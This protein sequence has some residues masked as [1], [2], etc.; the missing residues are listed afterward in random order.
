MVC[1]VKGSKE[2]SLGESSTLLK[3]INEKFKG[4]MREDGTNPLYDIIYSDRFKRFWGGNYEFKPEGDPQR[5][6]YLT[7]KTLYSNKEHLYTT[8]GEPDL[9][10]DG[11]KAYFINYK[12][13][14]KDLLDTEI[15][16][17]QDLLDLT[18]AFSYHYLINKGTDIKQQPNV[19]LEITNLLNKFIGINQELMDTLESEVN[20]ED[21]TDEDFE[22]P[23][24][25]L[26]TQNYDKA[27]LQNQ[28]LKNL[29]DSSYIFDAMISGVKNTLKGIEI[30]YDA[31]VNMDEDGESE[32][33]DIVG[34]STDI[35]SHTKES[36]SVRDTSTIDSE[37]NL[38]MSAVPLKDENNRNIHSK[39]LDLPL[40]YS[41]NEVKNRIMEN[42]SNILDIM[43]ANEKGTN[44]IDP[45]TQMINILTSRA[46]EFNDPILKGFLNTLETEY[47]EK[48]QQD[49]EAFQVRFFKSFSKGAHNFI[50]TEFEDKSVFNGPSKYKITFIN[51]EKING[52]V[53]KLAK[54]LV[55]TA[56]FRFNNNITDKQRDEIK[57][58]IVIISN[59]ILEHTSKKKENG[60][61][62]IRVYKLSETERKNLLIEAFSLL[63]LD[64]TEKTIDHLFKYDARKDTN[65]VHKYDLH[66]FIADIL[67]SSKYGEGMR[68]NK[69]VKD[70][71]STVEN[72]S[73]VNVLTEY[74]TFNDDKK[75]VVLKSVIDPKF[76][77]AI[78]M[79]A[80]VESMFR[81][82]LADSN[83]NF[84]GKSQWKF[85]LMNGIN[86]QILRWKAGDLTK[87]EQVA[88]KGLPYV[89]YLLGKTEVNHKEDDS[90]EVK[91]ASRVSISKDRISKIQL[92]TFSQLRSGDGVIEHKQVGSSDLHLDTMVKLLGSKDEIY[93]TY[94][95]I[96]SKSQ[97]I[98]SFLKKNPQDIQPAS[99]M[100]ADK[101][102]SY[103]FIGFKSSMSP[104]IYENGNFNDVAKSQI[105]NMFLGEIE[106]MKKHSQVIREYYEGN[107]KSAEDRH[108]YF[109]RNLIPDIHYDSKY[110]FEGKAYNPELPES[111]ENKLSPEAFNRGSW[112]RFGFFN[113]SYL[114]NKKAFN[115]LFNN[116]TVPGGSLKIISEQNYE[117][118]AESN[119][120]KDYES[121]YDIVES[122]IKALVDDDVSSIKEMIG[123]NLSNMQTNIKE[124]NSD[125]LLQTYALNGLL[126]N[127]QL[128]QMF[129]GDLNSYKQAGDSADTQ[130]LSMEDAL[131]RAPAP[132]TDG[133]Q[134]FITKD[135]FTIG[136]E[137]FK[138]YDETGRYESFLDMYGNEVPV[139]RNSKMVVAVVNNLNINTSE[140]NTQMA[141]GINKDVMPKNYG[142]EIA[143][144]GAYTT[145][146]AYKV[147]MSKIQS[148]SSRD[149]KLF[150][151]ML[152]PK[153]KLTSEHMAWLKKSGNSLQPQKLVGSEL[154]AMKNSENDTVGTIN[155]FLKYA[156]AILVPGLI[157]GTQLEKLNTKMVEQGIDQVVFKSGSK[158][159]NLT[160]TTIH[161]LDD[162]GQFKGLKDDMKLNP[163]A[164]SLS[165]LK[166]QVELP[167]HYFSEANIGTQHL[168]NLLANMPLDSNGNLDNSVKSY[169]YK[170]KWISAKQ[171]FKVYNDN[172]VKILE[173][174]LQDFKKKYGI[175]IDSDGN[176][177]YKNDKLR[178]LLIDQLDPADDFK[179]IQLLSDHNVPLETIP[180]SAQRLFPIL[181]GAVKK[182]AGKVSTNT[183]SVIQ[184]ANIG[185]DM[186]TDKNKSDILFLQQDT[187]LTPPK[188]IVLTDLKPKEVEKLNGLDAAKKTLY[189]NYMKLNTSKSLTPE[190]RLEM[191]SYKKQLSNDFIYYYTDKDGNASASLIEDDVK[192]G[193][194]KGKLKINKAKLMMP[195]TTIQKE[196]GIS[197]EEFK[198]KVN[199]GEVDLK[200]FENLISYR[201]PNQSISSNDAVEIVGILPPGS[202]DS[203]IVYH[204]ITTK[205]GSDFDVDK[206]YMMVP[207]YEIND[208][209][210]V[211]YSTEGKKGL[212]NDLIESMIAILQ[213]PVTYDD[214]ISP[215]DGDQYVKTPIYEVL[216]EYYVS[217]KE[218][219]NKVRLDNGEPTSD[220]IS[221][222]DFIAARKPSPMQQMGVVRTING[223]V[224]MLKA[225]NLVATMANHITDLPMS[226]LMK[227]ELLNNLGFGNTELFNHYIKGHE[228]DPDWKITKILLNFINAAK[229]NY[230]HIGNL[231]SYTCGVAMLLLR[232]GIEPKEIFRLLLHPRIL[233]ITNYKL[234]C[235]E[236]T[237]KIKLNDHFLGHKNEVASI[238]F[239]LTHYGRF[240]KEGNLG[241]TICELLDTINE[242]G[243]LNQLAFDGLWF[244]L[245]EAGKELNNDISVSKFDS[246]GAGK[247]IYEHMSLF[248]KLER[249]KRGNIGTHD[250]GINRTLNKLYYR[251]ISKNDADS[252]KFK[253]IDPTNKATRKD[254][255]NLT[256]L[257]AI[258]N[259]TMM[260]TN[261]LAKNLF[262]EATDNYRLMVNKISQI[263]G[264]NLETDIDNLKA[265]S[266]ILYPI[267]LAESNHDLYNDDYTT[268]EGIINGVKDVKAS[269]EQRLNLMKSIPALNGNKFINMLV[270]NRQTGVIEFPNVGQMDTNDVNRLKADFERI[271]HAYTYLSLIKST[272]ENPAYKVIGFIKE[273][274]VDLIKY[275][276]ISTGFKP[277][278]SSFNDYLPMGY[279]IDTNHAGAV[280]GVLKKLNSKD[281]AS[282]MASVI[283]NA[284]SL[285]AS[286][287]PTNHKYVH[288]NRIDTKYFRPNTYLQVNN[289]SRVS[290]E[291]KSIV[292]S[293]STGKFAPFIKI[294]NDFSYKVYKLVDI[295]MNNNPM[296]QR[297]VTTR[298]N[299][300]DKK[301]KFIFTSLYS[302][303]F[304]KSS[305]K[306]YMIDDAGVKMTNS[307]MHFYSIPELLLKDND[308]PNNYISNIS[309]A[310]ENLL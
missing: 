67:N 89:D 267:V 40:V 14:K 168:K 165:S 17:F 140:F 259:N 219:E 161:E 269:M 234:K 120:E 44:L 188:P 265:I 59:K 135:I 127:I 287:N 125:H 153:T 42:V 104:E 212:Q 36:T 86:N 15:I 76:N 170:G 191:N 30:A 222:D 138:P 206:L 39:I 249:A 237:T 8:Q 290:R 275:S 115:R 73:Y 299:K 145:L 69:S 1:S 92:T 123:S 220:I 34:S 133:L 207:S 190:Q 88:H 57:K 264:R 132:M 79:L 100:G 186:L 111:E 226:Q 160:T 85:T 178:S 109:L 20:N 215:L 300:K 58:R 26:K 119:E 282:Y 28:R 198:D 11:T 130:S 3:K 55:T 254:F 37:I 52:K 232:S 183:A 33:S 21:L 158:A 281:S 256:M 285:T 46:N 159:S 193:N 229:A 150:Q 106:S 9:K 157:A 25:V 236:L 185:Y 18:N 139:D 248:N 298:S 94:A 83:L 31:D 13:D 283:D 60:R 291:L 62:N 238:N 128:F 274:A 230:I 105:R 29:M 286:L 149:E 243:V 61:G 277:S 72:I 98:E 5:D 184:I 74:H 96:Q 50:I 263:N 84:A 276:F 280:E 110:K 261:M 258:M 166:W 194:G 301:H 250:N 41:R 221:Y 131:K 22:D 146:Q 214:L 255:D 196:L 112:N 141:K 252:H 56:N 82:E 47:E 108:N 16:S 242:D 208:E 43:S 203:A 102:S 182:Q 268:Q 53:Q 144:A 148:W 101:A 142:Y 202:G 93:D 155:V 251:G 195:F 310:F 271:Y 216:Y 64:V 122:D 38:M 306:T 136:D 156:P 253:F 175:E 77:N 2:G 51:P 70:E 169:P 217:E 6:E 209:G 114:N 174:Q 97:H 45:Y 266:R 126:N 204:E 200:I 304:Q 179:L 176:I 181:A 241:K 211:V 296:Y 12:G 71:T 244:L 80:N 272:P 24:F 235:K 173:T 210:N 224:D 154:I 116:M 257:G 118:I 10:F 225:K 54:S 151:E 103:G 309:L 187:K 270:F 27:K 294:D 293:R 107:F 68:V 171:M 227:S 65:Y 278:V 273:F 66:K 297:I 177:D 163:F 292:T 124:S 231:N 295:D 117:Q 137:L 180:N 205:A 90:D 218:A 23:N 152:D 284:M 279:F 91:E 246:Y 121:L 78:L 239:Y 201:I 147:N 260:L 7:T 233:Q 189:D 143:D 19:E 192:L 197:W 223:R 48:S 35:S 167:A 95:K 213:S 307:E 245:S 288:G 164:F 129:N 199:N 289:V 302:S 228:G 49:Q 305:I 308:V 172:V 81:P 303:K 162:E 4:F 134:Y 75:K 240:L 99:H 63:K 32:T 113:G 87:L 262:I 247:N